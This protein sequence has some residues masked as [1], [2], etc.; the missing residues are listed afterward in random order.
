[1]HLT[2]GQ[3]VSVRVVGISHIKDDLLNWSLN[4]GQLTETSTTY[5]GILKQK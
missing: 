5:A 2:V 1:M 3:I 4:I